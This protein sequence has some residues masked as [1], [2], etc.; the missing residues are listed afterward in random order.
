MD[1]PNEGVNRREFLKWGTL[2][3]LGLVANASWPRVSLAASKDRITVLS[4]I[5]LDSLHPY[6]HSAVR[7]MA[8]GST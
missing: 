4:S 5:A 6:A 7:S 8:F 2:A 1:S 3:G